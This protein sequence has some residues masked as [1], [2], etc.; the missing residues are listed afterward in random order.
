MRLPSSEELK[1]PAI[2]TFKNFGKAPEF[3]GDANSAGISI[4]KMSL[5]VHKLSLMF[6]S[7][8]DPSPLVQ[9]AG[10]LSRSTHTLGLWFRSSFLLFYSVVYFTSF[11]FFLQQCLLQPAKVYLK[12][13]I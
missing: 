11:F 7:S 4:P 5:A 8:T 13:T 2:C 10:V 6:C 12:H 9:K 3:S 1:C